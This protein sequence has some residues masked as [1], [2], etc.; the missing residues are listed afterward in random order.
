M[1]CKVIIISCFRLNGSSHIV[2]INHSESN[3]KDSFPV[4]LYPI[5]SIEPRIYPHLRRGYGDMRSS[6]LSNRIY[7]LLNFLKYSAMLKLHKRH[8]IGPSGIGK[9][10]LSQNHQRVFLKTP[11]VGFPINQ[12]YIYSSRFTYPSYVLMSFVF[13]EAEI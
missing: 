10:T 9:A 11:N 13:S 2:S 4:I 1:V 3:K 8:S 7:I 5:E 6:C 12:H